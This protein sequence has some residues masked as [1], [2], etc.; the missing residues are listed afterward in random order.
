MFP[1]LWVTSVFITAG[2]SNSVVE[3]C[4]SPPG[5][6]DRSTV[7]AVLQETFEEAT[8]LLKEVMRVVMPVGNCL[9]SPDCSAST[10]NWH[11]Y[12]SYIGKYGLTSRDIWWISVV[13]WGHV[14]RQLSLIVCCHVDVT[15]DEL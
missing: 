8:T 1:L 6:P 4:S 13:Q 15:P 9:S 11:Q 5:E 14:M 2:D 12:W 3:R 7:P 10:C